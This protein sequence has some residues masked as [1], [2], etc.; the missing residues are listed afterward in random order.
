MNPEMRCR[1]KMSPTKVHVGNSA[2]TAS[3]VDKVL[4]LM[5]EQIQRRERKSYTAIT[6]I[7]VMVLVDRDPELAGI[8]NSADVC[9]CDSV[10]VVKLGKREG[11]VIPRCYGPD[12]VIRC[13]DYGR[14]YG[15]RHFFLG[16]AEGVAERLADRLAQQFPGVQIAGTYCPPFRK[17]TEEE[18]EGMIRTINQSK[19][20]IVWVGLGAGKQDRWIHTYKDKIDATWFSGVGAA[21]D[22]ISGSTKRAPIFWQRLGLEWLYRF[23]FEPRRL[24]IRN[25]EGAALLA[26]F[27]WQS[28]TGESMRHDNR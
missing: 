26:K 27:Y 25:L 28:V 16:G 12:Y 19:P 18:I 11:K 17:M 3:G 1:P 20:D 6:N 8:I 9:F 24:F 7:H 13:C 2:F 14:Q 4:A 5:R 21:F 10:S 23:V 22:F 15:W